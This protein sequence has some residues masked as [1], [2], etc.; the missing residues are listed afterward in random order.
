VLRDKV[1]AGLRPAFLEAGVGSGT[2][3]RALYKT[4]CTLRAR[5][6]V[7]GEMRACAYALLVCV[8]RRAPG[9]RWCLT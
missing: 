2:P 1:L 7:L 6:L 8:H 5:M 9:W 3:E 4:L